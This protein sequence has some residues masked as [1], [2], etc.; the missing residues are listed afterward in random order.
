M[1]SASGTNETSAGSPGAGPVTERTKSRQKCPPSL[2]F[3]SRAAMP[4][5]EP[6]GR[7]IGRQPDFG[8]MRGPAGM[9]ALAGAS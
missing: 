5:E 9:L 1:S 8:V 2:T 7:A 4:A 6:S 3:F